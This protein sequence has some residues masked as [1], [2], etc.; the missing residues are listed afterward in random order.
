MSPPTQE[1]YW[2]RI[3]AVAGIVDLRTIADQDQDVPARGD[4][5]VLAWSRQAVV[6]RQVAGRGYR[7]VHEEVDVVRELTLPDAGLRAV[8]QEGL[9][10]RVLVPRE[11]AVPDHV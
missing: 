6:E 5:D 2:R 8:V 9:A 3:P 10:T 11:L 4:L 1:L 7:H